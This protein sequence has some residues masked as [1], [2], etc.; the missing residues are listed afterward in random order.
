MGKTL[1]RG[2]RFNGDRTGVDVLDFHGAGL[3]RS[4]LE[5]PGV[6]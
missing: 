6:V 2:M 4:G 5:W 1:V 3:A